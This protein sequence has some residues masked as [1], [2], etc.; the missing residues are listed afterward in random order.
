MSNE[1]LGRVQGGV[2]RGQDGR[3]HG[4]RAYLPQANPGRCL[5][6]GRA[7]PSCHPKPREWEPAQ[8]WSPNMAKTSQV[9]AKPG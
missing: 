6:R 2:R 7:I 5:D 3:T 1:G 4:K 9:M 8:Q